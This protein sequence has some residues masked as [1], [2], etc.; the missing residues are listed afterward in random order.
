[1][2]RGPSRSLKLFQFSLSEVLD[3]NAATD[4]D[5]PLGANGRDD[6]EEYP[7]RYGSNATPLQ[8]MPSPEHF[9]SGRQSYLDT[10][11]RLAAQPS[12]SAVDNK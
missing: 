7:T 11:D 3:V 12:V 2:V 8:Q 5:L 9:T 1:M 4:T 6:I 10:R